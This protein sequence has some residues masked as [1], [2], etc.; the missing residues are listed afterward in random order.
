[1]KNILESKMEGKRSQGRPRVQW[2]DNINEWTG[3]SMVN[4]QDWQIREGS[5]VKFLVNPGGNCKVN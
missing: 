1:M 5:G 3:Y 4:A 2:Y